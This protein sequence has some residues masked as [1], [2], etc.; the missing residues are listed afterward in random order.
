MFHDMIYYFMGFVN[1]K[2]WLHSLIHNQNVHLIRRVFQNFF[3]TF[4]N[5]FIHKYHGHLRHVRHLEA[6]GSTIATGNTIAK[7]Q[8]LR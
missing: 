7:G 6:T 1:I 2:S 4:K 8:I 3:K 5:Y